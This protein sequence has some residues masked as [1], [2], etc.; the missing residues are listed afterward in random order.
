MEELVA[1]LGAAF[2]S[3]EFGISNHVRDDHASYLKGW[4]EILQQDKTAIVSASSVAGK[5]FDYLMSLINQNRIQEA[6]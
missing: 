3:A 2:M 5:A 4:L 1:E 6:A